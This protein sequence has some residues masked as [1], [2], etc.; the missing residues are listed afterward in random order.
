[1]NARKCMVSPSFLVRLFTMTDGRYLTIALAT[2]MILLSQDLGV[3]TPA[4]DV[5][6]SPAVKETQQVINP[7]G[8]VTRAVSRHIMQE[9][10]TEI[11][12][13]QITKI[14][15]KIWSDSCL[16][17]GQ[18]GEACRDQ[19]V[20]GWQVTVRHKNRQA[21]VF[22]TNQRGETVRLD[23]AGAELDQLISIPAERMTP[24]QQPPK[25]PKKV[26]FRSIIQGGI[27]G[28]HQQLTLHKNGQLTQQDLSTPDQSAQVIQQI[29][30]EQREQ[31]ERSLQ[32]NQFG[33]F[34]QRIYRAPEGTSD[35]Q[36]ITFSD[37]RFSVQY[38]DADLGRLPADLQRVI[39]DWEQLAQ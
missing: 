7:I 8:Q 39:H 12:P 23:V 30:K 11:L 10:G 4:P 36:T 15:P 37:R 5:E 22:R 3:C 32:T 34:D 31:L 35:F 13:Q 6:I 2:G 28:Q 38:T 20:R 24:E 27:L 19:L 18:L 25:L 26:V 16:G 1:M 17:L 29:S 9:F 33:Q 14:E 21:W